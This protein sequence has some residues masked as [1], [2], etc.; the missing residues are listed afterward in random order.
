MKVLII[1]DEIV[2]ATRMLNLTKAAIPGA[3]ILGPVPSIKAAKEI[4]LANP[5][6][7]MIFSDIRLE[8]GLS[9]S[10]LDSVS[11]EAVVVFT[12][13]Y[14]EYALKAFEYNSIGYIL[15]PVQ[16]EDIEGALDKYQKNF[17]KPNLARLQQMSKE[18][19][20]NRPMWRHSIVTMI[21]GAE[22]IVPVTDISYIES[23]FGN[24]YI[25]LRDG[26]HGTVDQSLTKL[27][28]ELDPEQFLHVSRQHIVSLSSIR[29]FNRGA[30][31]RPEMC[32]EGGRTE[33]VVCT[34]ITF[35]KLKD[36]IEKHSRS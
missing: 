16:K 31:G 33:P 18:M 27:S 4:L 20:D 15:K 30:E 19:Q 12:T 6:I 5:D 7:N 11:S 35:N 24:T 32:M 25:Y 26:V 28:T 2:T 10:L 22:Q 21:R 17:L 14:N 36:I 13:A 9:F 29:T 34:R 23:E 3:E 1:E 8:D